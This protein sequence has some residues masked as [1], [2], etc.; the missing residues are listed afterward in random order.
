MSTIEGW[1]VRWAL[2]VALVST[3]LLAIASVLMAAIRAPSR[4][5]VAG[6]AML[7]VLLLV[8][9]ACA[10][11]AGRTGDPADMKH[12]HPGMDARVCGCPVGA[13]AEGKVDRRLGAALGMG[14]TGAA[15][16]WLGLGWWLTRRM[17]RGARA[18]C[19][20]VE[21]LAREVLGERARRVRVCVSRRTARP[22]AVGVARASIVLP[23]DFVAREGDEGIRMAIAHE[24][25]H[26]ANGDLVFLAMV[27]WLDLVLLAHPLYWWVRRCLRREQELLADSRACA[28]GDRCT[29]AALLVRWARAGRSMRVLPAG[30]I[31]L[32]G[33]G[34]L[35]RQRVLR[36]LDGSAPVE[37]RCSTAWRWGV[38]LAAVSVGA[39]L[40][41]VGGVRSP[42]AAAAAGV[43]DATQ[44]PWI[45][46]A[47]AFDSGCSTPAPSV[48]VCT[49]EAR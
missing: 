22:L 46:P 23:E 14:A 16:A 10:L 5:V 36:L 1:L 42:A 31:G 30:A 47:E 41:F 7:W 43:E 21:R 34:G 25:A 3:V 18:A 39:S 19:P 38:R 20:R 13:S 32:W 17:I 9:G 8:I 24:W 28:A 6:R 12:V 49:S 37:P 44:A 26:I 15:A 40:L 35:L 48:W 45:A 4:R 29:Y 27:R 11:R 2:D 33:R